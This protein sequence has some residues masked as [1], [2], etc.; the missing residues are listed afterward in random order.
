MPSDPHGLIPLLLP[1]GPHTV[2]TVV[3]LEV[4]V[5]R[6]AP[7]MGVIPSAGSAVSTVPVSPNNAIR[8]STAALVLQLVA[9]IQADRTG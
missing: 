7:V 6:R 8:A 3:T 5:V 9:H 2:S 1:A 4:L